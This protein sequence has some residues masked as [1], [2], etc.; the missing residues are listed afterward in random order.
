MKQLS[1]IITG[2]VLC[3]FLC[4]SCKKDSTLTPQDMGYSFFPYRAGSYMIYNVDSTY[5]D[6]F[7]HS[8]N[9]HKFLLKEFFESW[10]TD[11]QGRPCLRMERWV[12]M[13]DSTDWFLRDVWYS[14]LTNSFA[15]RLEENVRMTRLVFPVR[16]GY[17]WDGN[18]FNENNAQIYK[19]DK[20]DKPYILNSS[21]YDSTVKVNQKLSSNLVEEDNQYEIYA[22]HVGLIFKKYKSVKKD[23]VTGDIISGVDY[24]W[25]L[26]DY[27]HN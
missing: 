11:A 1:L 9:N 7:H 14:C 19:Y 2:V 17:K 8:V 20:V 26:I 21:L 22:R 23:F 15:E 16:T 18:A 6:D 27:G 10:F 3:V 4:L 5:Y 25:E 24:T 13:S 12:K